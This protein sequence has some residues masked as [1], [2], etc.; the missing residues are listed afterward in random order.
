MEIDT[1]PK[2]APYGPTF[3]TRN[4]VR[5]EQQ[6]STYQPQGNNRAHQP[7]GNNRAHQP[8][9][10]D[11]GPATGGRRMNNMASA[12][13][14]PTRA[15]YSIG[16]E[17]PI[18]GKEKEYEEWKEAMKDEE[19]YEEEQD[20]AQVSPDGAPFSPSPGG[21]A[22]PL[23]NDLPM[24]LARAAELEAQIVPEHMSAETVR[25]RANA[26]FLQHM[27]EIDVTAEIQPDLDKIRAECLKIVE[28]QVSGGGNAK[29]ERMRATRSAMIEVAIDFAD[30]IAALD[31]MPGGRGPEQGPPLGVR[32]PPEPEARA[33]GSGFGGEPSGFGV[34]SAIP[35]READFKGPGGGGGGSPGSAYSTPEV[36]TNRGNKSPGI[37]NNFYD[38]STA[39]F[40]KPHGMR[41]R[42]KK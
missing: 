17:T 5:S 16:V 18:K 21:S 40:K 20:R 1:R 4:S 8:Q 24:L 7:Q 23:I 33:T 19:G 15:L 30:A 10:P 29:I 12:H 36:D 9:G 14:V 13:H 25:Q 39:D 6:S 11:S 32:R 35:G 22:M 38:L 27:S 26:L 37:S 42:G 28:K 31:D 2:P 34:E 41:K 3:G